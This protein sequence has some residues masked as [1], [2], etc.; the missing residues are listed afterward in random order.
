M[1]DVRRRLERLPLVWHLAPTR[2]R[3]TVQALGLTVFGLVAILLLSRF[4]EVRAVP[5]PRPAPRRASTS[6]W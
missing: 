5:T 1:T 3:L 4:A 6:T 2:A